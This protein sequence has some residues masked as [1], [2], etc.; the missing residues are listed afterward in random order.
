M[1]TVNQ[2][3]KFNHID[4]YLTGFDSFISEQTNPTTEIV[5]LIS[6]DSKNI[7]IKDRTILKSS[8]GSIHD[9]VTKIS[10]FKPQTPIPQPNTKTLTLLI[11]LNVHKP[12]NKIYIEEC[13]YN[14]ADFNYPDA[15]GNQPL[16]QPIN[17]NYPLDHQFYT[18]LDVYHLNQTLQKNGRDVSLSFDPGRYVCNYIY[19]Y[20]G[21]AMRDREDFYNVF[22]HVPPLEVMPLMEQVET[23][24]DIIRGVGDRYLIEKQL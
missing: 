1:T 20:A 16:N 23:I 24:Q 19:C 22:V 12:I 21:L 3:N 9:Y 2:N 8:I 4:V 5:P 15:E 11:S 13:Y 7:Q 17:S 18:K 6:I 10:T 14:R